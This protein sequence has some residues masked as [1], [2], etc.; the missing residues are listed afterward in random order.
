M[1]YVVAN[2]H[3]ALDKYE[4]LLDAIRFS[5]VSSEPWSVLTMTSGK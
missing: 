1:T 4:A 3:G 5:K 2:L